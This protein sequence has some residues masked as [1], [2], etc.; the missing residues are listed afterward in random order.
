[1][2]YRY[3]TVENS[4]KDDSVSPPSEWTLPEITHWVTELCTSVR[5]GRKPEPHVDL[6]EQGFD[7]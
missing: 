7:R 6:F 2:C 5:E 1:M 4:G 3:E